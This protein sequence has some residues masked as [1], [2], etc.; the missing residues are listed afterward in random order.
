M[1]LGQE[2]FLSSGTKAW[3]TRMLRR[4]TAVEGAVGAVLE[5]GEVLGLGQ[6][7]ACGIVDEHCLLHDILTDTFEKT[8]GDTNRLVSRMSCPESRLPP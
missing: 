4:D 8:I 2:L 3:V 1:T 5:L 6:L 7:E